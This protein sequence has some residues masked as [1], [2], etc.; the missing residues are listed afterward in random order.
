MPGVRATTWLYT[1]STALIFSTG[2]HGEASA[3]PYI[4]E[5][6]LILTGSELGNPGVKGTLEPVTLDS[7]LSN[8]RGTETGDTSFVTNDVFVFRL[9]LDSDSL[10]V[11]LVEVAIASTPFFGNPTGAGAFDEVADQAPS[12]VS[13]PSFGFRGDF[14]FAGASL[15]PGESSTRLFVTY[16]PAGSALAVGRTVSFTLNVGTNFTVQSTIVPEPTTALLLGLGLVCIAGYRR[17]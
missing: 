7:S 6:P 4:L 13:L 1:I 15:E 2:F 16:G 8:P 17:L 9:T 10:S 12:S 11:D 5:A 3:L 14:E